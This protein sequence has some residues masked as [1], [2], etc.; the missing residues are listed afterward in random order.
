MDAQQG[1]V[2]IQP[3][4]DISLL[5]RLYLELAEDEASDTRRTP[6]EAEEGLREALR[7][8]DAAYA[9]IAEGSVVG[10]ALVAPVRKPPY[11]RH[12]YICRNARREGYGTEAFHAL[13]RTL[14]ANTLDL[15]VFVWNE[16]GKA[17][18]ASLGFAPR[19]TI[20]RYNA[21]AHD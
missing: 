6:D 20:M 2:T 7:S 14:G 3:C 5:A 11:L 13:L 18:W 21:N 12:F 10:Y 1:R 16:R 15:D 8:G 19:A 4:A 17:F 9:F